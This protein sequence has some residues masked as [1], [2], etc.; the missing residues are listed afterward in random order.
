MLTTILVHATIPHMEIGMY[1]AEI[2]RPDLNSL[3]NT[4]GE[5]GFTQLQLDLSSLCGETLPQHIEPAWAQQVGEEIR[6]KGMK[7]AALTGTFNMA[8]P[9][10]GIRSAGLERLKVI[11]GACDSFAAPLVTL[12][13]GSRNPD[14]MWVS[15]PDNESPEAWRDMYAGIEKACG[16][17]QDHKIYLGIEPEISNIVNY[18]EKARRLID[19]MASPWLKIIMDCANLFHEGEAGQMQDILK[20]AF[21][22][23]GDDIILAH[24][25]D[26]ANDSPVEFTSAGNGLVDYETFID[27]LYSHGYRGCMILHGFKSENDFP[28]GVKFMKDKLARVRP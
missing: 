19:D 17:A 18:A 13:T 7:I 11:I 1:T 20:G 5:Y 23:L 15:H 22:L 28:D 24:G 2:S 9:D 4:V 6:K 8:H 21:D 27:L 25:K 12:C 26:L 16:Y 14:S 3:L 10:A